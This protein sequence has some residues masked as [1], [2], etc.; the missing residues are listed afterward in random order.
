M[1]KGMVAYETVLLVDD[2]FSDNVTDIEELVDAQLNEQAEGISNRIDKIKIFQSVSIEE[3]FDA[4]STADTT[5]ETM[6]PLWFPESFIEDV[7]DHEG[8]RYLGQ[9]IAECI[10]EA[11]SVA[12]TDR[13]H[14]IRV[15]KDILSKITDNGEC[16]TDIAQAVFGTSTSDWVCID[17]VQ[18]LVGEAAERTVNEKVKNNYEL[19]RSEAFEIVSDEEIELK[20]SPQYRTPVIWACLD[21]TNTELVV[22][23]LVKRVVGDATSSTIN[24]YMNRV[25]DRL[26]SWTGYDVEEHECV[27]YYSKDKEAIEKKALEE[28]EQIREDF[29]DDGYTKRYSL[30]NG[31]AKIRDTTPSVTVTQAANEV[32]EQIENSS[33]I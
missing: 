5:A 26:I 21:E 12:Y 33:A 8:Q 17:E 2:R 19:S 27:Q 13:F 18:E 11:Y 16:E 24:E 1:S 7:H 30:K 3:H 29:E 6:E 14:R 10:E 23:K 25:Q 4:D 32:I 15:K 22:E 9:W 28:I 31:L 20:Q